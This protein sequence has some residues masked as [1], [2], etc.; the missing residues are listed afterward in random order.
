MVDGPVSVMRIASA[1]TTG[2]PAMPLV[3]QKTVHVLLAIVVDG[4]RW[5][6]RMPSG[7]MPS[8]SGRLMFTPWL[9][10]WI[11]FSMA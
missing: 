3:D 9:S 4:P 7:M 5:N 2:M 11:S 8:L 1:G 10:Y 6:C